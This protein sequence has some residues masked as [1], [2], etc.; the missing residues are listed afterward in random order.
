MPADCLTKWFVHYVCAGLKPLLL[1][2]RLSCASLLD[3]CGVFMPVF[4][5]GLTPSLVLVFSRSP[6]APATTTI[7]ALFT[8]YSLVN[9]YHCLLKS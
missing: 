1:S 4:T 2:R 8:F 6:R 3:D 9:K 5:P 7:I